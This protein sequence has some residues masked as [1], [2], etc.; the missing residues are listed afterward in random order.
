M[1]DWFHSFT[2]LLVTPALSNSQKIIDGQAA[3][4]GIGAESHLR[5]ETLRCAR[6]LIPN[7]PLRGP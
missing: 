7:I 6:G 2:N 5:K 4:I 1:H 3:I